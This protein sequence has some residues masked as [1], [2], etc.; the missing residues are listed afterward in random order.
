VGKAGKVTYLLDTNHWSYVQEKQPAVLRHIQGMSDEDTL[1]MSVVTQA[2]LLGGVELVDDTRRRA[3]L[4]TVYREAVE[5]ATE[6]LPVTSDVAVQFA[7]VYAS[8]RRKG[9]PID[10]NDMWIAATAMAHSLIVVSN[11]AHFAYID[12]LAVEDWT[13]SQTNTAGREDAQE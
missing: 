5:M 6:V 12:G 10:T 3:K 13:I 8:L 2:E 4:Y 9:R 1:Y 11:D 7:R